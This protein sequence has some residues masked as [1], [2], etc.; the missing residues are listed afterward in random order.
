MSTSVQGYN[1]RTEFLDGLAQRCSS[2]PELY[3]FNHRGVEIHAA[4]DSS[5]LRAHLSEQIHEFEPTW[6]LVSSEDTGQILLQTA[7]EANPSRVVYMARTMWSLPFG[8]ASFLVSQSGTN[9]L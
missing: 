6:I 4:T 1:T 9:L 3:V 7:L 2:S 8:P 5:Q